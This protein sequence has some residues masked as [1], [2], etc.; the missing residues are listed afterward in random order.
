MRET[1]WVAIGMGLL[2]GCSAQRSS[3]VTP[4]AD[5]SYRV[6]VASR[7][8]GGATQ[9][10]L[11]EASAYCGGRGSQAQMLRRQITPADYDL[12]FR[13][14]DAAAPLLS[15]AAPILLGS[16]ASVAVATSAMA[17]PGILPAE[18]PRLAALQAAAPSSRLPPVP[19]LPPLRPVSLQNPG[20]VFAPLPAVRNATPA[21]APVPEV[22]PRPPVPR[23]Y[24]S[25]SPVTGMPGGP[26]QRALTPLPPIAEPALAGPPP[27]Q[28]AASSTPPSAFW[29]I[30][31]N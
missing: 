31:R 17:R 15:G 13:C 27:R 28:G 29:G 21:F 22:L 23:A 14:A 8:L 26:P 24:E 25:L 6:T 11:S 10:A 19:D 20:P 16:A 1:V 7:N 9:Q 2:A 4:L 12:V 30:R 18:P 5:G 3:G